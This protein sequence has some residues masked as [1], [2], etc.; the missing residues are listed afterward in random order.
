[1]RVYVRVPQTQAPDI[2]AGQTAQV[3][4]PELPNDPLPAKVVTTSEAVSVTSRTLLT[5]LRADNP[6]GRIRT[7]AY[8]QVR[9]ES[10]TAAPK[11]TLPAS[12]LLFRAQG[13]Q[14]GVVNERGVVELRKVELGR[15]FGQRVEILNGLTATDKVIA[16]PPDS[17]VSGMTV[18]VAPPAKS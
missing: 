9:F 16:A 4:I 6:G 14:V 2:R 11:L 7:G 8:A 13:M 5:E 15:D 18:R 3:L 12:A 10:I 17:L 1:L